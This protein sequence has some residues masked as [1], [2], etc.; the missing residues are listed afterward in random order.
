MKSIAG[1]SA[2]CGLDWKGLVESQTWLARHSA[3]KL[4]GKIG[5]IAVHNCHRSAGVRESRPEC[6]LGEVGGTLHVIGKAKPARE[7]ELKRA[8]RC[9]AQCLQPRRFRDRQKLFG[10]HVVKFLDD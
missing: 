8:V 6:P 1:S 9:S 7:G 3:V 2:D 4:L 10:R 5:L